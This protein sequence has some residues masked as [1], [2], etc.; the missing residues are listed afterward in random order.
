MNERMHKVMGYLWKTPFVR[1]V[2]TLQVGSVFVILIGFLKSIVFARILGLEGWGAYAVVLAFTGTLSTFTNFGQNQAAFTFF[3]EQYSNKNYKGM[4]QVAKYYLQVT[5]FAI[6]ILSI[7]S[8]FAP[9]LSTLLYKNPS[10]GYAARIAFLAAIVG[11][12]DTFFIIALQTIRKIRLMTILENINLFLQFILSVLFLFLGMEVIGIFWAILLSNAVM[13]IVYSAIYIKIRSQYQLPKLR[14]TLQ[15]TAKTWAL[16]KQGLWIAVDKNMGKL[17]PQGFLFIM[18]LFTSKENVGIAQLAFKIG[19]V[20]NSLFLP[21][22]GRMATTVLPSIQSQGAQ[23]LRQTCA[24]IIKHAIA[25]HAALS[26]G[27]MIMLPY[28]AILFY[29]T[30]FSAIITPMLWIMLILML[31]AVNVGNSPL[32]RLFQKA[33][34]PAIWNI[35]SMPIELLVL[36]GFLQFMNPINAFVIII[37]INI[38]ASMWLS[39]HLYIVILPKSST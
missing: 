16:L 23:A 26:I 22:V 1:D 9:Q 33:H 10:V 12:L 32:Y 11:S 2:L 3:A 37:G 18:S 19:S 14:D 6:I 39:W 27:G 21:N 20:P 5:G 36:A 38:I 35:I 7:L 28:V 13:L 17:F 24:K 29:G 25:V 34:I 31:S 4:C 8:I 30:E 15:H